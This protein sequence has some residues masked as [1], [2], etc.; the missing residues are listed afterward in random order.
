M[1]IAVVG[2]RMGGSGM[3]GARR[4]IVGEVEAM[5]ARGATTEEV[6]KALAREVQRLSDVVSSLSGHGVA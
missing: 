1:N 2:G 4:D 6:V 5:A 3:A